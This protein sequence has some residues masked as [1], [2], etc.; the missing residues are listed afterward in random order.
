LLA[1]IDF[2]EFVCYFVAIKKNNFV[3]LSCL[4]TKKAARVGQLL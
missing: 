4:E 3:I 1:F 2:Q